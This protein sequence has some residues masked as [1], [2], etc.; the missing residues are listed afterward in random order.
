VTCYIPDTLVGYKYIPNTEV[1]FSVPSVTKTFKFNNQGYYGYD[2]EQVKADSVFRI[3]I[4]GRSDETGILTDGPKS[5]SMML[6]DRF[7]HDHHKVEII[8]CSKDGGWRDVSEL[9]DIKHNVVKFAPDLLLLS[10]IPPLR[11]RFFMRDQYKGIYLRYHKNY[12]DS[13]SHLKELIDERIYSRKLLTKM[14]DVSYIIRAVCRFYYQNNS[15]CAKWL[16]KNVL[17]DQFIYTYAT[18]EIVP[19]GAWENSLKEYDLPTSLTMLKDL[20]DFLN[21]KGTKLV[22]ANKYLWEHWDNIEPRLDSLG[23]ASISLDIVGNSSI[24]LK[25]DTHSNQLGHKLYADKMYDLLIAGSF[26]PD[27]YL[28]KTGN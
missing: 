16:K 15:S 8:N 20:D 11:E 5:W 26:I 3:C 9:Q 23:I 28:A 25:Y 21:E 13:V 18:K 14:Y 6:Q 4:V 19:I 24:F 7:S 12:I 17:H 1:H 27:K 10:I 2:F 22:I